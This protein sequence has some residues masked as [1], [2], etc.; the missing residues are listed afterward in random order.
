MKP[1]RYE[2]AAGE[3][4]LDEIDR[5][6]LK[7]DGLGSE[8]MLAVQSAVDVIAQNPRAWQVSEYS[9][10][11]RRFVMDRFPFAIVYVELADEIS[12]IAIAHASREP[13]YWRTRG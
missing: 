3:E 9:R 8:F 12:I 6:Q 11:A 1:V 10:R 4:L 2:E 7:R 13:G 5:Y